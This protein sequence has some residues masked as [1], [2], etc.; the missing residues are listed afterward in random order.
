MSDGAKNLP[1]NQFAS[2]ACLLHNG[3][4]RLIRLCSVLYKFYT[5]LHRSENSVSVK[6]S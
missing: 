4:A 5:Y 3:I 1:R 2:Y 6:N